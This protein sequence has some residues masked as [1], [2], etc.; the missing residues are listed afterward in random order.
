MR[1]QKLDLAK[2]CVQSSSQNSKHL[3][4]P[5]FNQAL[6]FYRM[7][8]FQEA[9]K[10]AEKALAVYPNHHDSKELLLLLQKMFF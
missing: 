6:M 8:E 9:H 10:Y 1:R 3:Y 5:L 4:E 7:G 2:A